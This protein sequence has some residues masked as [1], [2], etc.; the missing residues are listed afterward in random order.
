MFQIMAMFTAAGLEQH[1]GSLLDS[2]DQLRVP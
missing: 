1:I 2:A